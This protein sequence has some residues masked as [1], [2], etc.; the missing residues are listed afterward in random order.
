[1]QCVWCRLV[2]RWS[3]EPVGAGAGAPRVVV[4][5][6]VSV[7]RRCRCR[8]A[9]LCTSGFCAASLHNRK[10]RISQRLI[11]RLSMCNDLK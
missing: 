8:S 6:Q 5:A 7:A 9:T 2:V 1:M 3:E 11:T 10:I 4:G